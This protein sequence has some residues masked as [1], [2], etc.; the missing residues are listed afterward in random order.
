ME[1]AK[2]TQKGLIMTTKNILKAR[3]EPTYINRKQVT[4]RR[5]GESF[6]LYSAK[7]GNVTYN[8]FDLSKVADFIYE[9]ERNALDAP[10]DGRK[11]HEAYKRS[12]SRN[13]WRNARI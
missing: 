6:T 2:R 8:N 5:T 3:Q 13:G 4:D 1:T 10:T 9:A 12:E 7:V 11:P